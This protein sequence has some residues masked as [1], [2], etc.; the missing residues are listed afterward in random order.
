MKIPTSAAGEYIIM[1]AP[2]RTHGA[3]RGERVNHL[4]YYVYS[5]DTAIAKWLHGEGWTLNNL[6]H[7][8]TTEKH[9]ATVRRALAS[10]GFP[11]GDMYN[12]KG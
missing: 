11:A 9:K 1:Q 8:P 4:I 12:L 7:S 3:L 10:R 2:F 5:Y 6:S